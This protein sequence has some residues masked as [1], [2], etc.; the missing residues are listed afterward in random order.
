MVYVHFRRDFS[1]PKTGACVSESDNKAGQI[2][3]GGRQER[4]FKNKRLPIRFGINGKIKRDGSLLRL[5]PSGDDRRN[6]NFRIVSIM[7]WFSYHY[8]NIHDIRCIYIYTRDTPS[9]SNLELFIDV[10]L[11]AFFF[12]ITSQKQ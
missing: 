6:S 7:R 8:D 3:G 9:R 2:D 5:V 11:A 10:V 4:T 1:P 12:F